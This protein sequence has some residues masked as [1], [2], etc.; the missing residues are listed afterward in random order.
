MSESSLKQQSTS[1]VTQEKAPQ[2]FLSNKTKETMVGFVLGGMAACGAVTFTN[3]WEVHILVH[4]SFLLHAF[5]NLNL[6]LILIF[7]GC[8]DS[9]STSRRVGSFW[10][11]GG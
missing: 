11:L 6:F 10:N 5:Q 9:T 4:S 8:Q 2:Q 3:P 1:M 7:S